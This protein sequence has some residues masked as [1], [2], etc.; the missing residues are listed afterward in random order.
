MG[1]KPMTIYAQKRCLTGPTCIKHLLIDE[2]FFYGAF[3]FKTRG[4]VA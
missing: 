2:G 3:S 1:K 4:G